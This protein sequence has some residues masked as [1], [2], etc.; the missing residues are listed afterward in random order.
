[1]IPRNEGEAEHNAEVRKEALEEVA[2][3]IREAIVRIDK[4]KELGLKGRGRA[5]LIELLDVVEAMK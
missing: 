4:L 1:M 5:E 3:K 2:G